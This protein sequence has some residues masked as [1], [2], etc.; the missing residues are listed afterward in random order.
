M[1]DS[2]DFSCVHA[3]P[4]SWLSWRLSWFCIILQSDKLWKHHVLGEGKYVLTYNGVIMRRHTQNVNGHNTPSVFLVSHVLQPRTRATRSDISVVPACLSLITKVTEV[5]LLSAL[6]RLLHILNKCLHLESNKKRSPASHHAYS[7]HTHT[8][9]LIQE[10]LQWPCDHL[11]PQINLPQKPSLGVFV[12]P[13]WII[14]VIWSLSTW[15]LLVPQR[16]AGLE[17]KFVFKTACSGEDVS[18]VCVCDYEL[19]IFCLEMIQFLCSWTCIKDSLKAGC[20]AIMGP[21]SQCMC[22]IIG[23]ALKNN[24][25]DANTSKMGDAMNCHHHFV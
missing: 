22:V 18:W 23:E 15:V 3:A 16:K 17:H 2:V 20:E 5:A 12:F 10:N 14:L 24:N 6:C 9:S 13:W 4:L 25:T 1:N 19:C 11:C 7:K 21:R 8:L